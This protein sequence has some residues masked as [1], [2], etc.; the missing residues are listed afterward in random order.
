M[1]GESRDQWSFPYSQ[2]HLSPGSPVHLFAQHLRSKQWAGHHQGAYRP[3]KEAG[4]TRS[5]GYCKAGLQHDQE[6]QVSN[7][8]QG[9]PTH[10]VTQVYA[11]L[12]TL[13]RESQQRKQEGH[14]AT[15][16]HKT[17]RKSGHCSGE[18]SD[19][20]E[21]LDKNQ[22]HLDAVKTWQIQIIC[23]YGKSY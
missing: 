16:R 22:N 4:C 10:H 7:R 11:Y 14:Q 6:Q 19:L 17:V 23:K 18:M 9:R 8:D 15:P 21:E 13:V 5:L 12:T 3:E 20:V 2:H 1:G